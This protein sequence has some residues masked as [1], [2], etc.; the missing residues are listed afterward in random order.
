MLQGVPHA[1]T[2]THSLSVARLAGPVPGPPQRRLHLA[3]A[4]VLL[5][6]LCLGAADLLLLLQQCYYYCCC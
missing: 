2:A 6:R 1:A 5:Q 4:L 3:D